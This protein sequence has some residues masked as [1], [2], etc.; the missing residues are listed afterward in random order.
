MAPSSRRGGNT[1]LTLGPGLNYPIE[2]TKLYKSPGDRV[3]RQE[4]LFQYS[5]KIWVEEGDFDTGEYKR[6]LKPTRVEWS[7]PNDG[8]LSK[9]HLKVG[10]VIGRDGECVTI[11]EDC[12]HEIQY[13]KMCAL[14][15]QDMTRVDWSASR[16]S[17]SRAT[18]NMTHDNTGLLISRDAAARTDLEMQKRLVAQRKLVL[19]VDLDQTVIQTACEPTIG[20]WQKDPSNPNYEALKEVRS[21]ELPSEDG[22]RRNYTYYVKCRPGT[23]EFLNKV[24]NLFEM[25]VYTMATRA[26]AE[27]ILR[28][29]DPKKNLFGNRVISRNE[30]KG[31]EKTLQRIFP[32]STKMV[33]V[34][35]DRTDV[36]PQNRS[37]V[38]KVVP[39]NFYMIGDINS[40]F[41]PKRRDI[42]PSGPPVK[43]FLV[44]GR[45]NEA[46]VSDQPS[47]A[48]TAEPKEMTEKELKQQNAEQAKS[49]EKQVMDRPIL[50]MQEQLDKDNE[51]AA[52]RMEGTD[53]SDP[54]V[55]APQVHML[56]NDDDDELHYLEQHLAKLHQAWWADYDATIAKKRA[57]RLASLRHRGIV[58][59]AAEQRTTDYIAENPVP[60]PD[61]AN[62]LGALKSEVLKGTRIVLSG[63]I[64]LKE[65]LETCEIGRQVRSFGAELLPKV[66]SDVT[67][68]VVKKARLGTSKVSQAEKIPS[69]K[70]VESGWLVQSMVQWKH[71]DEGPFLVDRRGSQREPVVS[72]NPDGTDAELDSD[73]E[74]DMEGDS[75]GAS[76]NRTRPLKIIISKPGAGDT[77][78]DS[79]E[80]LDGGDDDDLPAAPG[81]PIDQL[82][83]FDWS[84]ADKEMAEFLGDDDDDSDN[85]D[86][87]DNDGN[88]SDNASTVSDLTDA[89]SAARQNTAPRKRKKGTED[90]TDSED[91]SKLSGNHNS[92]KQR[93]VLRAS[94]KLREVRIPGDQT[95]GHLPTPRVTG[96]CED[97]KHTESNS[98]NGSP[99]LLPSNAE[100]VVASDMED[101]DDMEADLMAA[102]EAEEMADSSL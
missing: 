74:A 2:I 50:H 9:W 18:I 102:L 66:S 26:Y 59:Q 28:I 25:H 46:A 40:T 56:F 23:H 11:E 84:T 8:K 30:N 99:T 45:N 63:I 47:S 37:N 1:V 12:T 71:L 86:G 96:D 75:S 65:D 42:I 35:D 29:I 91:D 17:T 78:E 94:S 38:I 90:V 52:N 82:K 60:L 62:H 15:G 58:G 83:S 7:A 6:V 39:Y 85:E 53:D 88:Y 14:C 5:N 69:I 81:S 4:P 49:L 79:G 70:I 54:S 80:G 57:E 77:D 97:E 27:H 41:L 100:D 3:K 87:E 10:D 98:A 67:H 32:T 19:V 101:Y 72:V 93:V 92:K 55:P 43:G 21:F 61:V 34:I 36:W 64:S 31:I 44:N 24:S 95:P 13:Q 68:L 48:A 73:A 22:P 76:E 51:V 89:D 20:E 16:P 33:A